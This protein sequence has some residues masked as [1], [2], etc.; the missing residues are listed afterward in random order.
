MVYPLR[1]FKMKI[2]QMSPIQ[3]L[4]SWTENVD[5]DYASINQLRNISELPIL[6]GHIAVMPDVH[7]G[8]GATVGSVIPT[9]SAIIPAAVGVDI[10]CGMI[11]LET[12]LKA[13][14][15]PDNLSKIRSTMESY[16]PVGFD[17]RSSLPNLSLK[18]RNDIK[19]LT[20]RYDNLRIMNIIG[21]YDNKKIL[22]QLGTL[23]G[24]NHFIELC[25]DES[26]QV[27]IMLHS[28]S[29]NIGK[30][31][32]ETA[33]NMAKEYAQSLN[34]KLP[35]KNLAWLE[36]G[37]TQFDLY[38]EGL[39]WAQDYALINR[40]IMMEYCLLALNKEFSRTVSSNKVAIQCHHNYASL[41]DHF[42]KQ[43]WLTRKGAVSA[44]LGEF[45]IIPGS[46]GAKSFIVKGKGNE[47]SYCSCSHGAGRKLSRGDAKRKFT[48]DDLKLQT[49]G[50]ECRK[51]ESVLDEIPGAYKDIDA[52]MESQKELVEIV[53]T[54]KQIVCIKG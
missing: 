45:G 21:T 38:V 17:Q 42:G 46:M 29:R 26:N 43:M 2:E 49:S 13:N 52:V 31:I 32:G 53:H 51:D 18:L 12:D 23:G 41:E 3:N 34:T 35:D 33:I 39:R 36:E 24:G 25:L 30:T 11:A 1:V 19:K 54:L 4:K 27:W 48:I 37:S 20:D 16:I 8:I 7:F 5:V 9:K 15:L 50:V 6:A 47:D 28:G 14:D 10:G 22:N 40:A 44:R